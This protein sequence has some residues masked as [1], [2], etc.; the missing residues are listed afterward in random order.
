[1]L[2]SPLGKPDNTFAERK[3]HTSQC[4]S[5]PVENMKST[6]YRWAPIR[7]ATARIDAVFRCT[8]ALAGLA[9]AS[10]AIEDA[11]ACD[12]H[13]VYETGG[14][15]LNYG[16]CVCDETSG[17][18]FDEPRGYG[19]KR[20]AVDETIV[21]GKC[22]AAMSDAGAEQTDSASA[23]EPTGV[24]EPCKTSADCAEFD[25]KYCAAQTGACMIEKC[26]TGENACASASV[27]CDYSLLLSGFSLCIP[28]DQ[29]DSGNC[30]MGG[31]K[32]EP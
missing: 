12:P 18:V 13:Q 17:Y 21:E 2:R 1:M 6:T 7:R 20:C 29:L 10:C 26:A 25:A 16:V 19:C 4:A 31:M 8:M 9:A 23:P 11:D 32:V 5:A 28:D 14:T 27:C 24:G 22:V 15:L 30:P 3:A